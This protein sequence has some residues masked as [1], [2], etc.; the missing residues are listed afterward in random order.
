VLLR[1]KKKSR[2][3]KKKTRGLTSVGVVRRK[4]GAN[5]PLG[6][7]SE[8]GKVNGKVIT[9]PQYQP[10]QNSSIKRK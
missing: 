7:A 1:A 3:R 6:T 9:V 5:R 8:K 2:E 4:L 10:E